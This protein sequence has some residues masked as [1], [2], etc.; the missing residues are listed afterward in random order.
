MPS[1]V[2]NNNLASHIKE[3]LEAGRE[4]DDNAFVQKMNEPE[5]ASIEFTSRR[6]VSILVHFGRIEKISN[7]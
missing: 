7:S 5:I 1:Q 3:C 6:I 4:I 2:A